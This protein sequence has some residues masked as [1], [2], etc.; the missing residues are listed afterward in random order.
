M[1]IVMSAER[2]NESIYMAY[3]GLCRPTL[4]SQE[5][6]VGNTM[7]G[8]KN[9]QREFSENRKV[10]L[11][12]QLHEC[13]RFKNLLIIALHCIVLYMTNVFVSKKTHVGNTMY[14]NVCKEK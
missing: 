3:A 9:K 13:G 8:K 10:K 11:I 4:N 2:F 6:H 5:T 12:K 1:A 7:Y 14:G